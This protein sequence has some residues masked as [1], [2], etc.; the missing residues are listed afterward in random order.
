[1]KKENCFGI[2][3]L[4]FREGQWQVFIIQHVKGKYWGFPKGHGLPFESTKESA[5]RELKEETGMDVVSYLPYP[6]LTQAYQFK[7]GGESVEKKICYYLAKVSAQYVINS[8]EI[9]QG[10]WIYLE[11][12]ISFVTFKDEE[13]FFQSVIDLLL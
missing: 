5:E 2:I 11:D 6:H 8:P 10:R 7:R 12:L 13:K 1:M 4:T 3:P 9:I